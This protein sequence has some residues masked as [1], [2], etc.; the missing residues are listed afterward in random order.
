MA[1]Q[2]NRGEITEMWN[3]LILSALF[4]FLALLGARWSLQKLIDSGFEN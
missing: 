4:V 2:S 3:I 1:A